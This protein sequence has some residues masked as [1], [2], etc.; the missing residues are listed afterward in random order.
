M[1]NFQKLVVPSSR[2]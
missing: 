1:R 2:K